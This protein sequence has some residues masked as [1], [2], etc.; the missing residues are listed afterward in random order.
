MILVLFRKEV[1]RAK[2]HI[3]DGIGT[4]NWTLVFFLASSWALVFLILVKGVQSSGKA[5][6]VLA[7]FP[8]VVLGIL[9]V[10]ALTL[11]GSMKGIKYFLAPQWDRILEPKVW[12]NGEIIS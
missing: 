8:Y 2:E 7:I 1:L 11:P 6:Y 12:Y 5:A 4:P 10:R 9:L 3:D